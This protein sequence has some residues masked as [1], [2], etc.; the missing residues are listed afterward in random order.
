MN[1][2]DIST[3][4]LDVACAAARTAGDLLAN[5]FGSDFTV[6]TKESYNLVSDADVDAEKAIVRVIQEAFPAH[7]IL[8]EEEQKDDVGSEHFWVID[9]LDGTN[10]FVHAIPHFAV[11][12]AYHH[13]GVPQC[14]VVFNPI[15]NDW[16]IAARGQGARA[17]GNVATVSPADD[18]KQILV[19]L[20]FYYD[21]GAMMEATLDCMRELF[22]AHVHGLR[23]MGTASLDLCQVGCGMYGAFFEY[24]LAPWD[25][26][27]GRLFVEEAGG[28]VTDC[29]G[30]ELPLA[31]TSL[32]A[33]NTKVHDA[34]LSIV[35][36]R[37]P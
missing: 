15:R 20:G 17:N 5:Y 21:R 36:K 23:R 19:G 33:S 29:R 4:E 24:E 7:A 6:R 16:Y 8:G 14:G 37:C 11:S 2:S 26:A 18:L 27:A 12:I 22:Q 34:V 25:F 3:P 35:E 32:L 30:N 31:R 1:P 9:P 10:N 13:L 28:K